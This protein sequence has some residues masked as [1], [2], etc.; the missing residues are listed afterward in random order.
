MYAMVFF[1]CT[2]RSVVEGSMGIASVELFF[3][4]LF[5]CFFIVID[6]LAELFYKEKV[7]DVSNGEPV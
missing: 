7:N 1:E 5:S 2:R 6:S 3:T 4:I